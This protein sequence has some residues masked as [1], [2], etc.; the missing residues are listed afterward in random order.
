MAFQPPALPAT[1]AARIEVLPPLLSISQLAVFFDKKIGTVRKQIERGVFPVRIRQI[2]GGEQ[3]ATLTDLARFLEDGEPQ[4]QPPLVR[5]AARNP[6]GRKGK[7]G[8]K[9]N[10]QKAA[11]ARA[12]QQSGV[13]Q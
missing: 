11:E 5:R 1:L 13:A 9:T 7:V 6:D 3:F 10:A 2:K 12:T 8:R 4:P